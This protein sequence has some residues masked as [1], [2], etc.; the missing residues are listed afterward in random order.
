MDGQVQTGRAWI[1]AALIG[2][3]LFLLPA[4]GNLWFNGDAAIDIYNDDG[5]R[6]VEVR[7]LIAGRGWFDHVQPRLGVGEGTWIHWSRLV[8]A[9]IAGLILLLTP[10]L[11]QTG[12]ETATMVIWPLLLAFVPI[13]AIAFV[14]HALSG[15]RGAILASVIMAQM[16]F[17]T[18]EFAPGSLDH[19]NVQISLLMLA[20][21]LALVGLS[22]P[23]FAVAAGAAVAGAVAV[24]IETLPHVTALASFLALLWAA[25]G[26]LV[27]R[28]VERFCIGLGVTLALLFAISAPPEAYLGGFCDSLSI[29]Q[30]LPILIGAVGL[31]L[32][33]RFLSARGTA[34][35]FGAL[36]LVAV[37]AL[38]EA[39][40]LTPACLSNP[41]GQLDPYLKQVWFDFVNEVQPLIVAIPIIP[42]YLIPLVAIWII[43]SISTAILIWL[44]RNRSEWI[45]VALMLIASMAMTL[46]QIRGALFIGAVSV[47]PITCLVDRIYG[48]GERAGRAVIRLSALLLFFVAV[49]QFWV[50]VT[51]Y[52]TKPPSGPDGGNPFTGHLELCYRPEAYET[53]R[54]LP[55]G[56]V[57]AGSNLGVFV[58][59]N[60]PHRT[61]SAPYHRNQAGM[62]AQ[63]GIDFATDEDAERQLRELGVDYVVSCREN[64]E[65]TMD[66]GSKPGF[67]FRLKDGDFPSFL[68]PVPSIED[69]PVLTVYRMRPAG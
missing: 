63:L 19:H 60:S 7:D 32:A 9:P 23:G 37:V 39:R 45:I 41:V 22:R 13:A 40:L 10:F 59:M 2:W 52:A 35:R 53:L 24:G 12:A 20:M 67:S 55:P 25:K 61:L 57:A 5:M 36:A 43:S 65:F 18:T 1:L 69:D 58:L 3:A 17:H 27:R 14:A 11:G 33:A 42:T 50:F 44:G 30:A 46:W 4:L 21:A 38:A 16:L 49:P 51:L 48:A 62:L 66:D 54:S 68:E 8:D 31:G 29:D 26:E 15:L 34:V 64:L 56:L 28:P 47:L 6:L